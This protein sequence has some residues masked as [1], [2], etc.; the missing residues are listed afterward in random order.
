MKTDP[1]ASVETKIEVH[2]LHVWYGKRHAV[3]GVSF[4]VTE[5]KTVSFIGATGSGRS[6]ILRALNRLHDL[7]A[8][9]RVEG[10]IKIDGAEV[11]GSG[12]DVAALRRR[13]GMIFGEPATLP[14]STYE[15]IV[16]GLRARGLS[17]RK[18]LDDACERSLRRV[19]LWEAVS[20]SLHAPALS[21]PIDWQQRV[22][23]AR[24]LAVSPEVLLFDDAAATLD[25]VASQVLDDIIFRLRRDLTILIATNDLHQAARLSDITYYMVDGEIAESGETLAVFNRPTDTRTEDFLAGRAW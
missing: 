20:G 18:T 3:R 14:L 16:F 15:N 4:A 12:T 19:M 6:A 11:L 21:L 5:R 7:D 25:P 13:V 2:D 22:C 1:A 17:D 10:S 8:T 9:A 23:V 24:A